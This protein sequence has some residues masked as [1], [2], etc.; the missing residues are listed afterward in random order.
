MH[1]SPAGDAGVYDVAV[2]LLDRLAESCGISG[3][4]SELG[5]GV[6][7]YFGSDFACG[8]SAHAVGNDEQ[9]RLHDEGVL[10]L[11]SYA[12]LVCSAAKWG[13]RAA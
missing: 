3:F 8:V 11:L 1:V 9:G 7:G 13:D 10:I 2:R 5:D 4:R 12:P 6:H